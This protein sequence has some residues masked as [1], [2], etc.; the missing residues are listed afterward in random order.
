MTEDQ[1]KNLETQLWGITNLL[2][3]KISA[4]DTLFHLDYILGFIFFKCL[5]EKQQQIVDCYSS[6]YQ[7]INKLK[8]Q[9][10]QTTLFKKGLLQR[11]FV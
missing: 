4:D 5:S 10:E 3:G 1:K 11:M 6:M 7:S 9:I 2:R 8:K